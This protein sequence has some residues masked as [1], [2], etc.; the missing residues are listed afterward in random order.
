MIEG[1]VNPNSS[2]LLE[3]THSSESLTDSTLVGPAPS[4]SAASPAG[5]LPKAVKSPAPAKKAMTNGRK[6][7][8]IAFWTGAL[9]LI[10]GIAT[11]IFGAATGNPV[12]LI[13]GVS[14]AAAGALAF[15]LALLKIRKEIKSSEEAP[16]TPNLSPSLVPNSL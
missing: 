9:A 2:Q 4:N 8:L 6:V 7:A 11:A 13:T 15:V 10:A 1:T 5:A 3:R 14:I 12:A 16:K